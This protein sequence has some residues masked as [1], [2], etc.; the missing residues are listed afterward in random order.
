VPSTIILRVGLPD[1]TVVFRRGITRPPANVGIKRPHRGGVIGAGG[2]QQHAG[3]IMSNRTFHARLRS[4]TLIGALAWA[5]GCGDGGKDASIGGDGSAGSTDNDVDA[6]AAGAGGHVGGGAAGGGSS[7]GVG[8][9]GNSA[10]AGG[11][12]AGA[13]G[14]ST[15]G[16]GAGGGGAP[17]T[18]GAGGGTVACSQAWAGDIQFGT[19]LDDEITGVTAAATA[20]FYVTGYEQG[21][22]Q[23]TD[24]IPAGGARAVVGRYDGSGRVIWEETIDS[25]G[26]AT[27]EDVRID[28]VTGNLIVLGRT[29]GAFSGFQNAGQF[30]IYVTVLNGSGNLLSAI[31]F[32]DERPQHPYRL[33]LG[34]NRKILVAGYDDLY[35]DVNYVA[36]MEHGFV[37]GLTLGAAPSFTLTQD[38]WYRSVYFDSPPPPRSNQDFTTGVAIAADGDGSFY[39]SSTV[40]GKADQRGMFVS[41]VDASGQVLWSALLD[42]E[43]GDYLSAIGLSPNGDLIVSGAASLS[44]AGTEVGQQDAFV[45]KV[46]KATGLLQW[47]TDAGSPGPDFPTAMAFD[48][49]GN[50]Y[51]TGETLGTFSGT[52]TN[53]GNIDIFA[54]KVGPSGGV[55]SAWERGSADD[56]IAAGIAVDPCGSVVIG[57]Y[58]TGALIAG[59]SNAGRRDMF[60]VKADLH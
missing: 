49:A 56:D 33:G 51:V 32:G 50:I 18:A 15:A 45:A 44:I 5:P 40:N 60:I 23:S 1:G 16:H 48:D 11:G 42:N 4:L 55:I 46:D 2:H 25:P 36:A 28:P 59:Q 37:A 26:A 35:I 57:G 38:F 58:T 24:V 39:V 14:G 43:P 6:G 21:D 41:K 31:Q 34:P 27:A 20:G 12:L 53:Q 10:G 22:D 3:E 7:G 17:G 47:A 30:D 8:G 52:A 19:P 13:S 29:S 9:G 54:V